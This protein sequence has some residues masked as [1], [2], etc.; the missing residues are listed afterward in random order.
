MKILEL[1]IFTPSREIKR[2]IEFN[3]TG[4]SIILADIK[5]KDKKK[6]TINSLG[7]TLLLKM[8]DYLYSS[9]NDKYYFKDELNNYIIEGKIKF[10]NES[11]LCSRTIGM[12]DDNTCLLYTSDA[13]DDLTTV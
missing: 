6:E 10:N 9:K 12:P 11:Y 2:K 4:V 13:A 8:I 5:R 7:K 3:E 1:K